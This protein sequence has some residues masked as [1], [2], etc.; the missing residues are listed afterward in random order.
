MPE[1]ERNT[2]GVSALRLDY[3]ETHHEAV[4][5]G[6]VHLTG[7]MG[8]VIAERGVA[9]LKQPESK[10]EAGTVT[11]TKNPTQQQPLAPDM[12][13]SLDRFVMLGN[14]RLRQPGRTGTGE[15]LTY[16]AAA[17]SFSLT[18][19]TSSPPRVTGEG[20]TVVTGATL[21][22]EGADSTIVVAGTKGDTKSTGPTRVHTETDLKQ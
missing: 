22:F 13:G 5:G 18:G 7:A 21:L 17:D 15:Q 20:G 12:G 2:L 16:T 6:D 8:E 3:D 4:F 14:V 9:F 1:A 10:G 19:T 11:A